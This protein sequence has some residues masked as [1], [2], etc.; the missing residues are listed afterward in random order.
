MAQI[1]PLIGKAS[2]I[3]DEI[4]LSLRNS[5]SRSIRYLQLA[6]EQPKRVLRFQTFDKGVRFARFDSFQ[7]SLWRSIELNVWLNYVNRL[8]SPLLDLGIGDG[9]FEAAFLNHIAIGLDLDINALRRVDRLLCHFPLMADGS[10]IPFRSATVQSVFSNS[11]LEHICSYADV[12]SEVRRIL[13]PGGFFAFTVP[14]I[15]LTEYLDELFGDG[16]GA[17]VNK[18]LAHINMFSANEWLQVFPALPC[19][20]P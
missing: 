13:R 20:S 16:V 18:E 19:K 4:Y 2:T 11:V 10:S 1:I 5:Y 3:S 14:T 12:I 17:S 9:A 7:F 6:G 15:Y 8:V